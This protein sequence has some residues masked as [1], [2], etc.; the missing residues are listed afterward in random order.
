VARIVRRP[1]KRASQSCVKL[2]ALGAE[3]KTIAEWTTSLG[4]RS[5]TLEHLGLVLAAVMQATAAL[6]TEIYEVCE[7][8][9]GHHGG[10]NLIDVAGLA[11]LRPKADQI[12]GIR[13]VPERYLTALN[14]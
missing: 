6:A 11:I 2:S 4:Q 8:G 10:S 5:P 1:R 13:P 12:D 3:V 14:D 9:P 7:Y